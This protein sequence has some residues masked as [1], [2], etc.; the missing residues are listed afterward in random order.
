MGDSMD[1]RT[2]ADLAAL[3]DGSLAPDRREALL[4]RPEMADQRD[5]LAAIRATETVRAPARLRAAVSELESG[6]VGFTGSARAPR[7]RWPVPAFSLAAI[8]AAV[9]AVFVLVGGSDPTVAQAARLALAPATRP[10]PA[11]HG[12]TLA[13]SVDGVAYPYFD[14]TD[15]QAAGSRADRLDGRKV[16]TV[17]YKN[18]RGQRVGYAIAE[19]SALSVKGGRLVDG[20]RVLHDGE[21]TIVT[22][23]RDGHTCILAARG[24]DAGKLVDLANWS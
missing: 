17:V 10:A 15:W 1:D 19:G 9:V 4:A 3:A 2:A 8:A 7:R 12:E 18:A 22:W 13:A 16:M 20:K 6:A 14:G 21:T 23:L 24:V 11:A 5:A